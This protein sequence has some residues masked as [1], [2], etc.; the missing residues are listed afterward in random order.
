MYRD[1]YRSRFCVEVGS[2]SR[3]FTRLLLVVGLCNGMRCDRYIMGI[4]G[5]MC[6]CTAVGLTRVLIRCMYT[7]TLH[8]QLWIIYQYVRMFV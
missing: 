1:V 2:H 4:R 8:V 5:Y 3:W 7:S 6:T